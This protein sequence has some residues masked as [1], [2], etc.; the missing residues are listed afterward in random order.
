MCAG[1]NRRKIVIFLGIKNE[2]E[3]TISLTVPLTEMAF[4]ALHREVASFCKDLVGNTPLACHVTPHSH[5]P[6]LQMLGNPWKKG[7]ESGI[8]TYPF[9]HSLCRE[10]NAAFKI[11]LIPLPDSR[12]IPVDL[13]CRRQD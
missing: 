3:I 12:S 4:P 2:R 9:S 5:R 7:V 11:L 8:C 6:P 13:L 10:S 1:S